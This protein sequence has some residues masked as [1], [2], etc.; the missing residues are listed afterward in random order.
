MEYTAGIVNRTVDELKA[1]NKKTRILSKCS[2]QV[3]TAYKKLHD[4]IAN[5]VHRELGFE[6][7]KH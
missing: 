4:K 6:L 7:V 3:Q 2:K 1:M 5:M